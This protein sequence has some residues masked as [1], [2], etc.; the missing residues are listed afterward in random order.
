MREGTNRVGFELDLWFENATKLTQS[1]VIYLG[2]CKFG[3]SSFGQLVT[4]PQKFLT[5]CRKERISFLEAKDGHKF[6]GVDKRRN[7]FVVVELQSGAEVQT[8]LASGWGSELGPG[9]ASCK[10][11][12]MYL[13]NLPQGFMIKETVVK[14][15]A[16]PVGGLGSYRAQFLKFKLGRGSKKLGHVCP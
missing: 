3:E 15:W 13:P 1:E 6:S 9:F 5:L 16:S 12:T 4:R 11:S 10:S 7:T 14:N 2:W 8:S